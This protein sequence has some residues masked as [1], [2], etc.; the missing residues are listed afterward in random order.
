[1]KIRR[2]HP[3]KTDKD[4]EDTSIYH[5]PYCHCIITFEDDINKSLSFSC[6]QCKYQGIASMSPKTNTQKKK[7]SSKIKKKHTSFSLKQKPSKIIQFLVQNSIESIL[8][9]IGLL[10]FT[11]PRVDNIKIGFTLILIAT[12][13]LFLM[14]GDRE[15]STLSK[16]I[17]RPFKPAFDKEH[18]IRKGIESIRAQMQRMR[19]IPLSNKSCIVLI[20]WTLLLYVITSDL[21]IY[22]ILIFIGIII[23][24]ELT[25]K[26]TSDLFKKRLNIYIF[27][28]L[29]TY[30]ILIGQKVIEI[31]ST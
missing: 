31:V 26:H 17:Y 25:D 28:F 23:T 10:F 12:F 27:L 18:R 15:S 9:V 19:S 29:I 16:N 13:L 30:V 7:G 14:T 21:E 20:I 2:G 8:I 4:D 5:C 3:K 1:M 11:Q 24:R 6:P 22:F